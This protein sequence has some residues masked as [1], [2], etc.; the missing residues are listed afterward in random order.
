MR[1][2]LRLNVGALPKLEGDVFRVCE[3]FFL[4]Y[5]G[6]DPFWGDVV[7]VTQSDWPCP[8]ARAADGGGDSATPAEL[9]S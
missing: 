4:G 5:V 1:I 9:R 7:V 3:E 8:A 6:G 2:R